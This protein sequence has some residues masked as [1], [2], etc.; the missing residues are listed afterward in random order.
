MTST[1]AS[2][3]SH[4]SAIIIGAGQAGLSMSYCLKQKGIDHLILEKS[5]ALASNWRHQRWDS[6]CLVTP[7]WQCQLPGF[8][9]AGDDPNGFMVKEQ[10]I[11]YIESYAASFN[12]PVVFNCPVLSLSQNPN[13]HTFTIVTT[14]QTYTAKQ[15]I[16]ASGSYHQPRILNMAKAMPAHIAHVHSQDY[17]N[18]QQLPEGEVMVV[19][20]GQSGAQIAEDLHLAGRKV[21]LCVGH[22]PRVNRRYRGKDV[23]NWLDEMGY[24]NTTLQTHPDGQNAVHSTNHYVTGRDGGRDLNLRIFAEQGMQLYGPLKNATNE[25]LY[26][27]D[28]L[29]KN[30]DY[31]DEVAKRITTSIEKYIQD[32]NIK[33]PKDDNINS[34]YTP[35]TIT[36]LALANTRIHSVVWATG[37]NMRFDW[38]QL[39]IFK[40]NG[41]P[42]QNRGVTNIP[43]CYFLGLNW[44]HTWGSGRFYQVGRDAEYLAEIIQDFANKKV[45]KS[46][47]KQRDELFNQ[48]VVNGG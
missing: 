8:N 29:A 47:I 30:L 18:P 14:Q 19:G 41:Y 28:E 26:F 27:T 36:Q 45:T 31:A 6:F 32:N 13:T 12:P 11:D 37:F 34:Q 7:N 20:T 17:K 33:A 35:P 21:H 43:G 4:Y 16:I 1:H 46:P 44:M 42:K 38:V 48:A 24:Y 2:N 10:I 39:P 22:A 3:N 25:Y 5:N 40:T 9:Y 23:V 15:V